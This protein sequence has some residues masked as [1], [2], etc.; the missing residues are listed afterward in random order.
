MLVSGFGVFVVL[1]S[2]FAPFQVTVLNTLSTGATVALVA[3]EAEAKTCVLAT[4]TTVTRTVADT[5]D[6]STLNSP[7]SSWVDAAT[8]PVAQQRAAAATADTGQCSWSPSTWNICFAN[9]IYVFTAG[10]GSALAYVAAVIL[11]TTVVFALDSTAYALQ[12]LTD[13][14]TVVRDVANMLF[15]F[16]LV[17]IAFTIMFR[18]ESSGIMQTLA[19]VLIM[20]VL[21]NFSFFITRVVIDAGN[22][23]AVQVYNAMPAVAIQNT[24]ATG[25]TLAA[26]GTALGPNTQNGCLSFFQNLCR[27]SKD[28]TAVIMNAVNI[29]KIFDPAYF[30]TFQAS[31]S[32]MAVLISLSLVYIVMGVMFFMPMG[33]FLYAAVMFLTRIVTLWFLII[34][35]PLAFAARAIPIE[36]FRGY[37]F[38]WQSLLI[39]NTFYPVLF[40]FIFLIL[41]KLMESLGSI[42]IF[43]ANLSANSTG[44]IDTIT[45]I[46][47]FVAIKLGLVLGVLFVGLTV[48][49]KVSGGMGEGSLKV[50]NMVSGWATNKVKGLPFAAAGFAGR[51]TVGRGAYALSRTEGV[52]DWASSRALWGLGGLTGRFAE[53]RLAGLGQRSF[54]ARNIKAVGGTV[55]P[56]GGVGGF[57]AGLEARAKAIEAQGARLQDNDVERANRRRRA[58]AEF[59]SGRILNE[60]GTALNQHGGETFNTFKGAQDD[61]EQ[62]LVEASRERKAFDDRYDAMS[63]A[64]KD[65]PANRDERKRRKKAEED[66]EQR[67]RDLD[68]AKTRWIDRAQ[69][70]RTAPQPNRD[71]LQGFAGARSER[72]I[73]NIFWPA[74]SSREGAERVRRLI[75]AQ[76]V[77]DTIA[78]IKLRAQAEAR[79]ARLPGGA[80]LMRE[81]L[82]RTQQR[83][84]SLERATGRLIEAID[85]RARSLQEGG[86]WKAPPSTRLDDA[87]RRDLRDLGSQIQRFARRRGDRSAGGGTA[88]PPSDARPPHGDD[89]ENRAV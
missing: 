70:S 65:L 85:E 24:S 44:F 8:V 20:A 43:P 53:R 28:I 81:S 49:K 69:L 4:Q 22:I 31:G 41:G 23:A 83:F 17:Y 88:P 32:W 25:Q 39:S 59:A 57:A 21:I 79:A 82:E 40:L 36:K 76:S 78:G 10:L 5:V 48:A 9:V 89:S 16:I 1:V 55:G 86:A 35:S 30:T 66:A 54:D 75:A 26:V 2:L 51:Q 60:A 45:G 80:P 13:G 38:Q 72:D 58:D 6:C 77:A 74:K 73:A 14:W 34:A 37:Y 7:G 42:A 3:S 29:Q 64:E 63:R 11:N 47:G 67:L 61:A 62:K 87:S 68:S 71:R 27:N 18:A 15:L 33:A 19:W 84:G 12:F 50:G 46:L 56:G 52:R